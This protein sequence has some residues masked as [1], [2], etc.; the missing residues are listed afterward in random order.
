[1]RPPP[2]RCCSNGAGDAFMTGA[3]DA[4]LAGSP[5]PEALRTGAQHAASVLV[6]RHLHPSL[7]ALLGA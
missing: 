5:L 1:M 6:T 4:T 7:D 3:L 2:C